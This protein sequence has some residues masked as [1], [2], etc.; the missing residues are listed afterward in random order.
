MLQNEPCANSE[1]NAPLGIERNP[2]DGLVKKVSGFDPKA[3]FLG[4]LEVSKEAQINVSRNAAKIGRSFRLTVEC[5]AGTD[6]VAPIVNN[7]D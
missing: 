3:E 2:L 6:A 5:D 7:L 1:I 4:H